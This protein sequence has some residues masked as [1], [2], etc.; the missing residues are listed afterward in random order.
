M[1]IV[2][3][4][5]GKGKFREPSGEHD[6]VDTIEG[7]NEAVAIAEEVTRTLDSLDPAHWLG[8]WVRLPASS[9][10]SATTATASVANSTKDKNKEQVGWSP[11]IDPSIACD[12]RDGGGLFDVQKSERTLGRVVGCDDGLAIV[13]QA[14]SASASGTGKIELDCLI[15]VS[16]SGGV[17]AH[18]SPEAPLH[19]PTEPLC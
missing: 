2:Q 18:I 4:P 17:V 6:D 16:C 13:K 19:M 14:P 11:C 9:S 5:K 10:S 7:D 15:L 8:V 3:I 1:C 12:D